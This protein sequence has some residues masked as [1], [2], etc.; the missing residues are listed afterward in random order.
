MTGTPDPGEARIDQAI[1][2]LPR[3]VPPD[4]DL[5]PAIAAGL[6]PRLATRRWL[7]AVA[8]AVV[9]VA[10]SSLIT[11]QLVRR[12]ARPVAAVAPPAAPAAVSAARA[13]F[14]PG[15]ALD[16]EYAAA[17]QQL[18]AMLARRIDRLPRSARQ[19]L[20]DNLAEMQRAADEINAALALQPGDP[21]L[22]ELLLNTY[23][24][25]LAVLASV[26]QLANLNGAVVPEDEGIKL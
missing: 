1:A 22:E 20:E 19:K 17:R 7:P 5:W 4:R 3:E 15:H 24:D 14:G 18:A 16:K 9:L 12:A 2:R 11:A 26:N 10:A 8:A 25:E 21:L 23:Q 6:E 13:A